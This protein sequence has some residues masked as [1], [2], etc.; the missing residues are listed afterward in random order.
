VAAGKPLTAQRYT[1]LGH[2][3]EWHQA[4]MAEVADGKL[5]SKALEKPEL[6]EALEIVRKCMFECKP[7]HF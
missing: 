2:V 4:L 6:Q 3:V 7:Q 5:P 1:Y